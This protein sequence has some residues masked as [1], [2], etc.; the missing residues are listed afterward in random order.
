M[1]RLFVALPL[2]EQVKEEIVGLQK[3]LP[4]AFWRPPEKLHVTL[5]FIGAL[6]EAQ[7][8]DFAREL[9]YIRFPAFHLRL[10]G[11]GYFASGGV[12]HHVWAGVEQEA[13]VT[14]LRDKIVSAARHAGLENE[15]RFKFVPHV[16]LG[17]LSGSDMDDVFRF[18][19]ANNLFKSDMFRA[20][21]FS[22]FSSRARENGEGKYYIEEEAYPLVL[23]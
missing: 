12:P 17:R 15:D 1:V 20:E 21:F 10:K 5:R 22:L 14:E 2:P 9:R 19:A 23:V 6:D 7:A 13:L 18:I 4:G 3:G 16:T 11:V 8:Q